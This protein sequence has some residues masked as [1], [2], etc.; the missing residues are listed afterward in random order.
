MSSPCSIGTAQTT[1]YSI[2]YVYIV[3]VSETLMFNVSFCF[4]G[5][6]VLLF[7]HYLFYVLL[8]FSFTDALLQYSSNKWEADKILSVCHLRESSKGH[9]ILAPM[10]VL[11]SALAVPP[12]FPSANP[13]TH[14]LS[15]FNVFNH[16]SWAGENRGEHTIIHGL[17][18]GTISQR[19]RWSACSLVPVHTHSLKVRGNSHLI[20]PLTNNLGGGGGF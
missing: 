15:F 10:H 6:C 2:Q 19:E 7:Y 20:F 3:I 17:D 13:Y 4:Q 12:L 8:P 16:F 18:R 5:I 11:S 14:P 9:N 1:P